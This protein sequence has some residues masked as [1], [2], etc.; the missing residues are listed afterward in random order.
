MSRTTLVSLCVKVA[1]AQASSERGHPAQWT[2]S[3]WATGGNVPAATIQLQATPASGGAPHFSLGCTKEGTPS[4]DLG[5]VN[6]NSAQRQ[7]QAQVTVTAPATKAVTLTVVGSAAHL[8]KVLEASATVA[9]TAPPSSKAATT[10]KKPTPSAAAHNSNA[11]AQHPPNVPSA[12]AS[13]TSQI[14]VGSLPSIPAADPSLSP[15]GNAAN[16]FPTLYPKPAASSAQPA[17]PAQDL[18][19]AQKARVRPVANTT[20][21]PES[22]TIV[23]AQLAGLAALALGFVLAVTRLAIRRRLNPA[24]PPADTP[25]TKAA[26]EQSDGKPPKAGPDNPATDGLQ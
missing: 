3:A 10:K 9:I 14:P 17:Q 11:A 4:C 12:P 1:A 13:V 15:G 20:A 6:A 18:Q 2:V 25:R 16:L 5:A 21:L 24:K 22:A 23:G 8:S 7:L 26:T 19:N